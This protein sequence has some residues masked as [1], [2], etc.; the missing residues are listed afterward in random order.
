M[1]LLCLSP[2]LPLSQSLGHVLRKRKVSTVISLEQ[3]LG[4]EDFPPQVHLLR[5]SS[6]LSHLREAQIS[7]VPMVLE[8]HNTETEVPTGLRQHLLPERVMFTPAASFG[9]LP[10]MVAGL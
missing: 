2:F 5:E 6:L 9:H 4:T 1:Y 10:A 8:K 3:S 7:S